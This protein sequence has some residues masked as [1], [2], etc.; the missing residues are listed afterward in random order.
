[1]S[2]G[3]D[4]VVHLVGG[5]PFGQALKFKFA[6]WGAQILFIGFAKL[7]GCLSHFLAE[8]CFCACRSVRRRVWMSCLTWSGASPSGK[9]SRSPAGARRSS[10]SASPQAT[11]PR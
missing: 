1:M 3:V 5:E 2:K 8:A 7:T 9:R 11:S 10:S 6:R 4:V